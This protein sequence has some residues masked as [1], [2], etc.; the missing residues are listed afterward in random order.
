MSMFTP[1]FD[2]FQRAGKID[3][4]ALLG[5]AQMA[6]KVGELISYIEG[7][8]LS[9]HP[10]SRLRVYEGVFED[11]WSSASQDCPT[12]SVAL[13]ESMQ[14]LHIARLLRTHDSTLLR[15]KLSSALGGAP[16]AADDANGSKARSDQAELYLAALL[17]TCGLTVELAEPDL[18]VTVRDGTTVPVAIK[19]PRSEQKV[20]SNLRKAARQ[21]DRSGRPGI[22]ALDLSFIER[23]EKPIYISEP[24]HRQTLAR[25]L[26][27]G[28]A[29]ENAEMLLEIS[30]RPRILGILMHLSCVVRSIRPHSMM[31]STRLLAT[32][33]EVHP[34]LHEIMKA[35]QRIPCS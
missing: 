2:S 20:Q 17:L 32:G 10:G 35:I 18:V 34:S 26:L 8:G 30:Q 7:S 16:I 19:R 21:I 5:G 31:V 1:V 29:Q 9:V 14:F 13:R 4:S 23:V 12:E 33:H 27:D 15:D 11:C 28:Y 24:D 25:I 6:K 22:I 3:G